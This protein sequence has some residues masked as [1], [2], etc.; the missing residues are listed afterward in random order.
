[1]APATASATKKATRTAVCQKGATRRGLERAISSATAVVTALLLVRNA[2]RAAQETPE[3][4]RGLRS[5]ATCIHGRSKS[6]AA[7]P[8]LLQRLHVARAGP[9]HGPYLLLFPSKALV[10]HR[11]GRDDPHRRALSSRSHEQT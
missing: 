10:G 9:R 8:G 2:P 3:P 11:E 5:V 7:Q 1:K 4:R 6:Y